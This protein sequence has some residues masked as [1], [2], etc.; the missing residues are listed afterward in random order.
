MTLQAV[1]RWA[2]PDYGDPST[3]WPP[4]AP[5]PR[6]RPADVPPP[7]RRDSL[8]CACGHNKARHAVA[9]TAAPG[10]C[11][12]CNVK[13][14]RDPDHPPCNRFTPFVGNCKACR[15]DRLSTDLTGGVC[16]ESI[17]TASCLKRQKDPDWLKRQKWKRPR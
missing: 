6:R 10:A 5:E 11:N 15:Q 17:A 7:D 3:P 4:Q 2:M 1:Q 14:I 16:D 12:A 9:Y 13:H 8:R